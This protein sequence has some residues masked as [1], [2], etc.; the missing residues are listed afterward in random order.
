VQ[1]QKLTK[2]ITGTYTITLADC[3]YKIICNSASPFTITLP[4]ATGAYNFDAIIQ[5]KGAG[6]VTCDSKVV[7]QN[8]ALILSNDGG[9]SWQSTL[10]D[11]YGGTITKGNLTAGSS[12]ISIGGTGTASLFGAGA[13]IDVSEAN[14]THNNIGSKQGGASGE[15]YHLTANQYARF[16]VPLVKNATYSLAS[17]DPTIVCDSDTAFSINLYAA[18]G[19]GNKHTIKNINTGIIT[20]DGDSS[21][22]IDGQLTQTISQWDVINVVDYASGKWIIV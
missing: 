17:T 3:G 7:N 14:L 21:E 8:C 2:T 18:T 15:Y 1:K 4:S 10:V 16:G 9:A 5:N 22:T 12:K 19:S 11:A 20:I 6:A 13:S